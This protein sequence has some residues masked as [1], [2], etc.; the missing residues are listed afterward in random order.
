[1]DSL[2][3]RLKA[4]SSA[5]DFLVFFGV[6]YEERT[7]HVN[8]LHILKR[9][10]QYLHKAT[11]LAGLDDL[12]MFRRYRELLI[13]AHGDFVH[14]SAAQEKVFKVFQ[15]TDGQQHVAV[16][17]L[18]DSLADR[19]RAAAPASASSTPLSNAA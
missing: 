16:S 4:L 8:R 9:F 18:R 7:V 6:P 12:E 1:M 5:E 15:N 2:T 3:Q 13:Q 17:S 19:R 11:D 14:S 10:Y